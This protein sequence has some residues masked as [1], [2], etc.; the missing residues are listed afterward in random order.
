MRFFIKKILLIFSLV[1]ILLPSSETFGKDIKFQ[2]SEDNISN[3]LSGVI[4]LNQG[5]T[6]SGFNY[7]NKVQ[8][9]KKIH[10]NFNVKFIHTLILLEKFDKAFA[11]SNS[12]WIEDELFFEIDLLL[13]LESFIKKISK[14]LKN[15]LKG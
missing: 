10:S 11:F 3:Y 9:L 5:H 15:I 8:S 12:I 7:L 1:C 6:T 2:Y 13:G 4:S 14:K